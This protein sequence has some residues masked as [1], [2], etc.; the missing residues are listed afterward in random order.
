MQEALSQAAVEA[1]LAS[2]AEADPGQPP[3]EA[4]T[5]PVE[6]PAPAV[7]SEQ[8][9]ASE[10]EP[11]FDAEAQELADQLLLGTETTQDGSDPGAVAMPAPGSDEFLNLRI[12]VKTPEGPQTVT[13]AE[14]QDGF[15]RQADYTRKTQSL[16][17][18]RKALEKAQDFMTAFQE[19]P[20]GFSRSLAVQAGLIREGDEPVKDIPSA[21][22]PTQEEID[23]KVD[24][25]AAER[26]AADPTVQSAQL[27]EAQAQLNTEFDRLQTQFQIPL[28][29][30]VRKSLTDEAVRTKNPDIEGLLAKRLVMA[31]QSRAGATA[32]ATTSRPGVPP[33][34]ATEEVD[35]SKPPASM[36]EAWE[37][38]KVAAAQQ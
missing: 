38:A 12:E 1:G 22:I 4:D 11:T 25:L 36:R 32:A 23:T 19:D 29:P 35:T 28:S 15:L 21:H 33:A 8:P 3:A 18:Q 26:I 20:A 6:E 14:L 13:V 30:E 9:A 37:Q 24:E 31:Q 17:E 2:P 34:S 5:A 27:R 16:A 10:G 7:A